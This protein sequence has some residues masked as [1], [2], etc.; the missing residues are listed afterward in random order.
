MPDPQAGEPANRPGTY[1]IGVELLIFE[2]STELLQG[3]GQKLLQHF[4]GADP[5]AAVIEDAEY[6]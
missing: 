3:N 1:G 5:S 2:L 4:K 6:S